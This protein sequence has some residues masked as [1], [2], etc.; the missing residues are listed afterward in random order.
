MLLPWRIFHFRRACAPVPTPTQSAIARGRKA[1]AAEAAAADA[2]GAC[3]CARAA[4]AAVSAECRHLPPPP[5]PP[6]VRAAG[7]GVRFAEPAETAAQLRDGLRA[8][9]ALALYPRCQSRCRAVV[10]I[11]DDAV[12]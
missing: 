10:A 11:V 3:T 12:R 7:Q 6:V 4:T 8:M 1:M 2:G 9:N 5:P